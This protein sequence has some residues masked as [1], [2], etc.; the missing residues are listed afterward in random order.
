MTILGILLIIIGVVVAGL[1]FT[2]A[3]PAALMNLGM[4][5]WGWAAVAVVGVVLII[6][7][8]RPGD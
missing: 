2:G 6:F 7:N 3:A 8:R 1:L 5:L 4:P